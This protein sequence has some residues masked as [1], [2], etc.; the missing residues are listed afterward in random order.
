MSRI[1]HIGASVFDGEALHEDAALLVEDGFV[2]GLVPT[3]DVPSDYTSQR[4]AG[5]ILVPG[6]VDLQVNGGGGVMLNDDPSVPTLHTIA[7]AHRSLGTRAL[8]PTLI[9]DTQA[10]ME[11]AVEAVVRAVADGVPGIVGLHLEGPHL[12]PARKGAHDPGLIR[13]MTDEDEAFLLAA[14]ARLPTLKVTLAPD[15]VSVER[16]GRLARAGIVVSLGHSACT[17]EQAMAAADAGARCV[18]HLFNAMEPLMG[19]APGLVGAALAHPDLHVGVIADGVHVHPAALGL[20]LRSKVGSGALFA[21][22]DAMAPA[23]TT[24]TS[25]RLQGREIARREGRLTLA[26][27]TLAG[28]DLNM[29]RA[30]SILETVG[31]S[32]TEALAMAT[33]RPAALLPEGSGAGRI[34][35]GRSWD[36]IWLDGKG[37]VTPAA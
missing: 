34:T 27:G 21:I 29:A 5:G 6:F 8:L 2:A 12:A 20:A 24:M 23:A 9:T 32:Q 35:V 22:T 11:A 30:V 31:G 33:S 14:A 10:R 13:P 16:I 28:A 18:T 37:R 15:V 19:R 4:H 26:D 36:G 25:F 7:G 1:A 17:F 3:A